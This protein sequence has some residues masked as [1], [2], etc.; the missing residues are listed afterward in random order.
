MLSWGKWMRLNKFILP[1]TPFLICKLKYYVLI[2]CAYM[3]ICG[4]ML[5]C[6]YF[7]FLIVFV[8]YMFEINTHTHKLFVCVCVCVCVCVWVTDWLTEWERERPTERQTDRQTRVWM[9]VFQNCNTLLFISFR[10]CT[11]RRQSVKGKSTVQEAGGA[12][13]PQLEEDGSTDGGTEGAQ[14]PW[15]QPH[16]W[17]PNKMGI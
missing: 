6:I 7:L 17:V 3:S 16:N 8:F 13:F 11:Q 1:P 10:K 12:L 2:L 14:T 5:T 4:G 15:A 9:C